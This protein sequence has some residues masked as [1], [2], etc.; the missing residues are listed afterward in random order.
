MALFIN[1]D[2]NRSELQNRIAAELQEKA[3]KKAQQ[4]SLP[5]GVEDSQYIRGTRQTKSRS[6]I[7]GIFF[8]LV[9]A[10]VIFILISGLTQ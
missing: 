4:S 3:R 8:L 2:E 6:W 10:I 1:Q 5:D 7:Y 9:V